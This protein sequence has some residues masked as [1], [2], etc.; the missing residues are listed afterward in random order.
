MQNTLGSLTDACL[1]QELKGTSTR[2][3]L[4]GTGSESNQTHQSESSD[5]QQPLAES[6]TQSRSNLETEA[7]PEAPEL[8]D[9]VLVRPSTEDVAV[10][11]NEFFIGPLI[12][13]AYT[14]N[15]VLDALPV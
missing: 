15:L 13:G 7:D 5:R 6:L 3:V 4:T 14:V 8:G 9:M 10:T 12:K 2:P 1:M 11:G